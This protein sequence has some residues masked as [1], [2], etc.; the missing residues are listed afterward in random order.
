MLLVLLAVLGAIAV[1]F[2]RHMGYTR[3]HPLFQ[4][5]ASRPWRSAPDV[6]RVAARHLDD[7]FIITPSGKAIAPVNVEVRL[8]PDDLAE[9]CQRMDI[10]SISL[11]MTEAYEEAIARREARMA[12]QG[13]PDA[14]VIGDDSVAPGRF[15]IGQGRPADQFDAFA[16]QESHESQV[17]I[18]KEDAYASAGRAPQPAPDWSWS[19]GLTRAEPQARAGGREMPTI[20][21][22]TFAPVPVLRLVTG[23]SVAETTTSGHR[24]GRGNVELVLPDVA[25]ISREHA[26]FTYSD[27]KWWISNMGLNGIMLNGAMVNEERPLSHGDTIRWGSRP[28]AMETKVEIG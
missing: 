10:G 14:Y 3:D 24:A 6:L 25:T 28:D 4:R 23:N 22:R 26:R 7:V 21:E 11:S 15:R 20:M 5:L 27:G 16:G 9:L 19:D 8:N 17:I 18:E 13:R 12:H 2:A 1:V